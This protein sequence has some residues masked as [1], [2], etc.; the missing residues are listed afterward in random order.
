MC[1][2]VELY[3]EKSSTWYNEITAHVVFENYFTVL[4]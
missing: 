3:F 2:P 4:I 1:M